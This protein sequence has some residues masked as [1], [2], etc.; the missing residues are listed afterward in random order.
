MQRAAQRVDYAQ[1][2]VSLRRA[3]LTAFDA[4]VQTA[5]G[6]IARAVSHR[7]AVA[8]TR[9]ELVALR[10]RAAR[11]PTR[12]VAMRAGSLQGR[13]DAAVASRLS[14]LRSQAEAFAEALTLLDP[15]RVLARGYS[16]VRNAE[17]RTVKAAS[18]LTT[19]ARVSLE[20][21]RGSAEAQIERLRND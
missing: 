7:F 8:R 2:S 20:F 16:I 15:T 5:S 10:L 14:K 13:L 3:P 21:G 4:R 12:A 18:E 9:H 1:R 17:G 11:E 6:R 19:G